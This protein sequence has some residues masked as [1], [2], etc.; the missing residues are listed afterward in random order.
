M[1]MRWDFAT[2]ICVQDTTIRPLSKEFVERIVQIV[3]KG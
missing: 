1:T 3:K 2:R